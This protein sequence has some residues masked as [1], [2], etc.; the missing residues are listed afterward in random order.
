[1][2][3]SA[4]AIG[5]AAALL[6]GPARAQQGDPAMQKAQEAASALVKGNTQ[7]ALTLYTEALRDASLTGDRRAQLHND[8]GVVHSR[9]GHPK[10]AIEDFNRA[11]QLSP[12]TASVYN[13]R[14]IVLLAL[15]LTGE[16]IKDFD[17]AIALAPGYAAAY[18]NRAGAYVRL[19]QTGEA[20]QDYTKAITLA[21]SSTA[22]LA[23]R[24]RAFLM[25]GRPYAAMR[26]FSRA[27]QSDVRFAAG[28]RAR[29]EAKLT[30]DRYEDAVEDL[31]RAIAFEPANAEVLVLRGNAYL[32]SRN[33]SSA[34]KDFTKAIE[35]NSRLLSA[36]LGR[37]MAHAKAEAF[38]EA[39]TD[40]ARALEIEPRSALAYA[41]RAYVYKLASQSDLGAKELERALKL[42]SANPEVVWV[43]G[44]IEEA[45]GRTEEAVAS[46]RAALAA[47]P[48]LREAS[49]ALERLGV[50]REQ[51]G[52]V[53]VAGAGVENWRIIQRSGRFYATNPEHPK[54][55]I[56]LEMMGDGRPR[57]LE[58]DLKQPPLKGIG[59]LRFWAGSV[60]ARTGPEEVEQVAIVDLTAGSVVGV[61]LHR[62]GNRM[63]K[64][65]WED[66]KVV[67]ASIDGV[68]DELTLRPKQPE[69]SAAAPVPRRVS[70]GPAPVRSANPSW[71]PWDTGGGW[72]EQRSRPS[73][74]P[75]RQAKPKNFFQLLF[76]N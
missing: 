33:L 4:I 62:Q 61:S 65:T 26:D 35:I 50:A 8:R 11:V 76:G 49:E 5:V 36:H 64:W 53:E 17:R 10:H 67:V 63:S 68:T 27:L 56:P 13:N 54:L 58:W 21:P 72:N 14:G 71:V 40:L 74:P 59:T 2:L 55:R 46:Y 51:G 43:K 66:S 12:E 1:M 70:E 28:Y 48:L 23:G 20:I 15:G 6:A 7:L 16:A 73:P 45:I 75:Q 60:Q 38:E 24:G 34:V 30:V 9:L 31:S 18:N 22:P 37:A 69:A 3:R 19:D 44:E 42:D 52:D 57:L 39:E 47:K 29:A 41:Y 25:Q 32:M